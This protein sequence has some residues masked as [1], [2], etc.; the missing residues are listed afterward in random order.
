MRN[1]LHCQRA[2]GGRRDPW[3]SQYVFGHGSN[4]ASFDCSDTSWRTIQTNEHNR[5][6]RR[7]C[8]S[9]ALIEPGA[10]T[11]VASITWNRLSDVW[12]VKAMEMEVTE[13]S[14]LNSRLLSS[15][16]TSMTFG[17]ERELWRTDTL[18]LL[19]SWWCYDQMSQSVEDS[20]W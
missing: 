14:W 9:L 2:A 17:K 7:R 16:K 3:Y 6:I 19:P 10:Y 15:T 18:K 4:F 5:F 20:E 8:N 1:S 11:R 13:R 12:I